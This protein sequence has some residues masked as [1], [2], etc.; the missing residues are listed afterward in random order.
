MGVVA[1]AAVVIAITFI[2]LAGFMIPTLIEIRK[3]AAALRTYITD[4]ESQLQPVLK[5]LRELS[6]N[7]RIVTDGIASRTDEVKSFMTAIGDTG[8]NI[9]RIN[10]AIGNVAD[11]FFRSSLWITGLKAAGR[12]VINRIA[13]KGR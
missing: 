1:V 12:Y 7:L 8:R 5:E 3:C 4:V 13:K 9:S 6:S 11:I 10:V 2:V